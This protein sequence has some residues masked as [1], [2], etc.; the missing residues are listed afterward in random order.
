LKNRDIL[1]S[2]GSIAG[3]ALAYWLRRY[4]FHPTI[5]ERVPAPRDGGHATDLRGAARDVAERMGILA[6]ARQAR[7]GTRGMAY[8]NSANK[9]L[10]SMGADLLGDSGGAVAE[11]E[12]LRSDLVRIL[13]TATRDEV[14]YRFDDSITAISQGDEGVKITFE[15]GKPCTFDLL[16]GADGLHSTVRAL[17][18]GP[19]SEYVRHLGAYVSIFTMT[20]ALDLAGWELLYNVPG[21]TAG[22]YPTREATQAKAIFFFAAPPL[23]YDYR[24]AV[25]QKRLL[26]EAFAG[27][28][29]EVPRLLEAMWSAPD[30]YFDSVSQVQMDCWSRGRVALVGDAG[31]CVSPL[32]GLGTSLALVG[33]YV[34]AGELA[35][36]GGDYGM[37]FARYEQEMRGYVRE[38]Q[39]LAKFNATGLIPRSRL[40]IW[41][42][43]QAMRMIAHLPKKARLTLGGCLDPVAGL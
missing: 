5:V 41:M 23:S 42:R 26:A 3:P 36:A 30:F 20:T 17:A 15:R 11:I 38:G 27:Q 12:I 4:G 6:A 37:A 14:E 33:A 31:Y 21:K 18:F 32:A 13:Y 9:R 22:L 29:W 35:E 1:I 10:V 19:E 43:N 39:K 16:V 7:I 24:D 28:G 25:Q 8:V 40:Q 2:G 34:L